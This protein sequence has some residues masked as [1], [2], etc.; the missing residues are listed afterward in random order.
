MSALGDGLLG[1]ATG[2]IGGV[3]KTYQDNLAHSRKLSLEDYRLEKQ[4]LLADY[5]RDITRNTDTIKH[6]RDVADTLTATEASIEAAR[7][8][9]ESDER[10]T[11]ISSKASASQ[12]RSP[13]I[14]E[15]RSR[16]VSNLDNS[17]LDALEDINKQF[18]INYDLGDDKGD[19]QT[20][21]S[22]MLRGSENM[23]PEAR[24]MIEGVLEQYN[25]NRDTISKRSTQEEITDVGDYG[26]AMSIDIEALTLGEAG[27]AMRAESQGLLDIDSAE[28]A[29]PTSQAE[30]DALPPGTRYVTPDGQTLTKK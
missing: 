9:A 11:T 3:E 6:D 20:A 18:G 30:Y 24:Q 27:D 25:V 29:R 17:A 14:T 8:K 10:R 15:A 1:F 7:L 23:D 5:N 28:L 26:D 16:A 4:K 2:A 21:A 13:H 22:S 19:P 12:V